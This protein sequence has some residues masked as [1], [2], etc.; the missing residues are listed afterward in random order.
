MLQ[1]EVRCDVLCEAN[2]TL[3]VIGL[4]PCASRLDAGCPAFGPAIF[5]LWSP[6]PAS[7]EAPLV[8]FHLLGSTQ[9]NPLLHCRSGESTASV[10]LTT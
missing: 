7:R 2:V 9:S 5:H 8:A 4:R 10:P 6:V 1:A 3:G